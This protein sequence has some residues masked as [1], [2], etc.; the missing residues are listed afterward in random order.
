[1]DFITYLHNNG[2]R[3]FRGH[4]RGRVYVFFHCPHPHKGRWYVNKSRSSFQC[5][6]CSWHCET[7]DPSDFQLFLPLGPDDPRS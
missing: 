7:D 1:M 4:V 6:G 2:Y 3:P 5:V